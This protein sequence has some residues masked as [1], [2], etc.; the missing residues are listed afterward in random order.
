MQEHIFPA[1]LQVKE[2]LAKNPSKMFYVRVTN[3]P[4]IYTENNILRFLN[5][6]IPNFKHSKLI[7]EEKKGVA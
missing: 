6:K 7:M 1:Q 3:F 5:K 2:D 4:N